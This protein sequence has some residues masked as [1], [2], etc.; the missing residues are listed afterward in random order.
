M[1]T[2]ALEMN[3]LEDNETIKGITNVIKQE[4]V[5]SCVKKQLADE[6]VTAD[7]QKVLNMTALSMK[8]FANS[9][10]KS[11]VFLDLS[12]IEHIKDSLSNYTNGNESVVE[13][14]NVIICDLTN[15]QNQIKANYIEK[16]SELGTQKQFLEKQ[17]KVLDF[18]RTKLIKER[19]AKIAW[20]YDQKTKEYD[21]K[22][23]KLQ[24]QIQKFEQKIHELQQM[25]PMASEKDILVFQMSLK[26]KL[27]KK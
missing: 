16:L 19:L 6:D 25:R 14:K 24:M 12:D 5:S 7:Y 9:Y 8:M 10:Y 20:P 17:A 18:E 4:F 22:I 23:A 26:D 11:A 3:N 2:S 1:M 15:F 21:S 27:A 13:F